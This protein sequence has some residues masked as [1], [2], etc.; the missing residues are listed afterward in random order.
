LRERIESALKAGKEADDLTIRVEEVDSAS[1]AFQKDEL[2]S[3]SIGKTVGG[4]VR[5]LVNGGWGFV[6]FQDFGDLEGRVRQAIEHARLVSGNDLKLAEVEPVVDDVPL[7]LAHHPD[8]VPLSDKVGMLREYNDIIRNFHPKISSTIVRYSHGH[9]KSTLA[10]KAGAY[11]S[12]QKLRMNLVLVAIVPDE[13]GM[14]QDAYE[15]ITSMSDYNEVVGQQHFCESVAKKALEIAA[16]PSAKAGNYTVLV[17]PELA[18]VF[19]HEAFGHLSE[20]DFIYENPGWQDILVLGKKMG[21]PI[22]NIFDGGAVAGHAGTLKYDDEGTPT[23]KTYL[24]K[25]GVLVGRLHSRETAAKMDEKPTGNARA[26]SYAY[27][28][29]VRMTNT[30]I[31]P[32]ASML[33]EILR[34]IEYGIYAIRSHGG[35][36]NFEQ[37][38]FGAAEGF[39]IVKGKIGRRLRNVSIS[40]NLFKTLENIDMV[41][42]DEGWDDHGGCGKGDQAGLPTGCGGA[43][44]RIQ[45]CTVGGD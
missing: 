2:D 37:F 7:D 17:D 36:T 13:D 3:L 8:E 16:A 45:D 10:N 35:Q 6:S 32:G 29:I 30:A 40:G 20:S 19:T 15:V 41:A 5:A 43:H 26:I 44:I 24:I 22:L 28:P 21:Q 1:I 42:S 11:I 18:G 31:E 23:T 34:D 39:E 9:R 12:Q 14:P 38:T 27:P 4:S 25:D 33:D